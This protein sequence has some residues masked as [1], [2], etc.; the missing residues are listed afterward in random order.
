MKS[1]RIELATSPFRFRSKTDKHELVINMRNILN[2]AP[3]R[4]LKFLHM[5]YKR[6]NSPFHKMRSY[7]SAADS[8]PR[9]IQPSFWH[10]LVPKVIRERKTNGSH[11]KAPKPKEWNPA[12]FYIVI[13]LLIGS[14]AIQMITLRNDFTIFSRKADAKIS[15]LKEV[16]ERVHRGED[17]DVKGLLGTGN[18]DQE[19]EWEEG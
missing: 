16:L 10:S 6:A 5:Q 9:V 11:V 4:A 12:T 15:L 8:L 3:V 17:V 19:K 2:Q 1:G 13:F 18:E 14:N 7:T